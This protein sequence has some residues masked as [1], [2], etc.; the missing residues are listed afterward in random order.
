[1]SRAEAW[2]TTRHFLEESEKAD[3]SLHDAVLQT[4]QRDRAVLAAQI[5]EVL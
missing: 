3:R 2:E 5:R 1:M 4:A